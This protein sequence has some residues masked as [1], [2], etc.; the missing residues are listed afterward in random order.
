M[1]LIDLIEV[2]VKNVKRFSI[3]NS[4]F[5]H[6]PQVGI[7]VERTGNLEIK[8]NIFI[9]NNNVVLEKNM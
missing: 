5:A 6:I 3:L 2:E 9:H 4:T 8:D 7:Y 1:R